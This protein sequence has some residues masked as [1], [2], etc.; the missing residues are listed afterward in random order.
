M[1]AAVLAAGVLHRLDPYL[2]KQAVIILHDQFH[3]D[4]QISDFRIAV[5]PRIRAYG[6]GLTFRQPGRPEVPP[7]IEIKEFAAEGG[8]LGLLRRPLRLSLVEVKGLSI[9]IPPKQGS[10]PRFQPLRKH[11]L[12]LIIDEILADDSQLVIMPKDPAKSPH[13]FQIH[14][15]VMHSLGPTSPAPFEADLTNAIPPGE[16]DAKGSFGPWNGDEPGD[17]ALAANFT[18]DHADLGAIKGISGTLSSRGKFGGALNHI[19]V[20]GET[21]TPDFALRIGG[22]PVPLHTDYTAT[23]DGTNGNTILHSVR[24][25]FLNSRVDASGEIA[26]A[27]GAKHR[28]VSLK[29]IVR[30]GRIEDML[31]L[32]VRSD[33]PVMTGELNLHTTLE[34]PLGEGDA[35]DHLML[36]GAFGIEGAEFTSAKVSGKIQTLSRKGLGKPGDPDAGSSVSDLQGKFL[37]KDGA[38][39]FRQL[40]FEV[41]GAA[42]RLQGTYELEDQLLDFQGTL[43]LHAKISQTMTGM[44]SLILKPFDGFF[45]KNHETVLPIKISGP[46]EKPKFGLNLRHSKDKADAS[47]SSGR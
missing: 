7:L 21:D 26:R 34:L 6:T 20:Q 22:S 12:P 29:A 36:N 10:K 19:D 30:G 31:H 13:V 46:R 40:G 38:I 43:Q 11:P 44:K 33:K 14:R 9:H 18:F 47:S 25:R 24:A 42:V 4:V 3:A 23:V 15:L 41:P 28:I 32:A 45:R 1:L 39:N 8:F 37:L 5:F 17:T 2:R 35:I 16:I 27:A